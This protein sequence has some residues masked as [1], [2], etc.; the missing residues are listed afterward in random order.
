MKCIKPII[1]TCLLIYT[2]GL[3]AQKHLLKPASNHI[4]M[5]FVKNKLTNMVA[6][7]IS[8]QVTYGG[9]FTSSNRNGLIVL[10]RK[11]ETES[12]N[13]LV[14]PTILPVMPILNNVSH[15]QIPTQNSA[16]MYNVT[17]T[18]D[19]KSNQLQW[20]TITKLIPAD[21]HIPLHTI[22]IFADPSSVDMVTGTT[23]TQFSSQLILPSIYVT[24]PL[25]HN[26]LATF[27]PNNRPFLGKLETAYTMTPYGYATIQAK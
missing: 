23:T 5:F 25:L 9:Y 21:G 2:N 19:A 1:T 4:V 10:P 14:T 26:N 16:V 17:L 15:W 18:N 22:I 7:N 13:I 24:K 12:F 6:S 8:L 20:H 3:I 27:L 11:T